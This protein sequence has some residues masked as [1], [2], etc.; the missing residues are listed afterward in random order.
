MFSLLQ[1]LIAEQA[2]LTGG[3]MTSSGRN[4]HTSGRL[5]RQTIHYLQDHLRRLPIDAR[6]DGKRSN[7]VVAR[8]C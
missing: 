1:E 2:H 3:G 5:R 4:T 7:C 8:G 6:P